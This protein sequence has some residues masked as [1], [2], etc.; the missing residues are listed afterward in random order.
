VS[1][2][3]ITR[4][5]DDK[6]IAA[7]E[8]ANPG[9]ARSLYRRAGPQAAATPP[10]GPTAL[11]ATATKLNPRLAVKLAA[12]LSGRR[13][14]ANPDLDYIMA[15]FAQWAQDMTSERF[16]HSREQVGKLVRDLTAIVPTDK[17]FAYNRSE[18]LVQQLMAQKMKLAQRDAFRLAE[19]SVERTVAGRTLNHPFFGMYPT[20]YMWGKV[21]PET[22]KFLAKDAFGLESPIAGV[23]LAR[24]EQAIA[25]QREWD[26]KFKRFSQGVGDSETAFLM[27]YLTPGLPWS[28]MRAVMPPWFRSIARKKGIDIADIL[29]SETATFD[30]RRWFASPVQS[31]NEAWKAGSDAL[32][33][34]QS[35]PMTDLNQQ[36]STQ[37]AP[38]PTPAAP[39]GA[40]ADVQP[41]LNDAMR[42]LQGLFSGQ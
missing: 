11:D 15:H 30:P 33:G 41:V 10:V 26:P 24:V 39:T 35:Q 28:D 16:L 42:E 14:R 34:S 27:D 25:A 12:R 4:L 37:T 8:A 13:G 5:T 22:V 20:S 6:S 23:T 17:A 38:Q 36:V 29:K 9:A 1:D 21:F 32:K 2:S 31:F 18:A 3:V 7:W 19:M 40:A